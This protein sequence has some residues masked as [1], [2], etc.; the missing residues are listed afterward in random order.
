MLLLAN[1]VHGLVLPAPTEIAEVRRVDAS[2]SQHASFGKLQARDTSLV[3]PSL[4]LAASGK[5]P[6]YDYTRGLDEL[7]G[8]DVWADI[9]GQSENV[10]DLCLCLRVLQTLCLRTASA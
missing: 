2:I 1:V 6:S 5:P 8:I 7:N 10:R 4:T 9:P 3:F